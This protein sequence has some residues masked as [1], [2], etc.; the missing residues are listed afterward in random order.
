MS[1]SV[2]LPW[3]A[4]EERMHQLMHVPDRYDN[5]TSS[6]LTPQASWM[7]QR[8]PLLAIGT[9][10]DSGRPWTTIWGGKPGFS[11]P[12]GSSIVGSRTFV[13]RKYDPVVQALVGGRSDGEV[14]KGEVGRMVSGLAIDLMSRKRVK[15]Y[16]RMMAAA[17]A[18]VEHDE[19]EAYVDDVSDLSGQGQLQLVVKIEQSLGNCPKYLNQKEIRPALVLPKLLSQSPNLPPEALA[20]VAKSDL[21]FISSSNNDFDMDTNHRGGPPG[22]VRVLSNDDDGAQLVYPEYSGNRLYQTL[23]NLQLNP[24]A[25]L[26]FPD[27]DTGD[28]LYVTGTVEILI[29]SAAAD[30]LPRSNLALKIKLTEARYVKSGLPFR[31]AAKEYSPYNPN[32]RL[33]AKEDHLY[34]TI[35]SQVS[36]SSN[37]ARLLKRTQITPNIHRLRFSMT[38]PTFYRPGQWV[39][40]DFSEE[41]DIGYSHMRDDDPRS[42]ND[43]FIRTFTIS[44]SPPGHPTTATG[45]PPSE[46][47]ITIRAVGPVTSFL[48]HQ[49]SRSGLSVPL[50]GIGGNFTINAPTSS[51]KELV[52]FIAGGVGITPLL[53]HLP[54]LPLDHLRLLWTIRA[55]DLPL[56]LDTIE[57]Y[58]A[59][60]PSTTIFITSPEAGTVTDRVLVD[61][62]QRG[63][64]Y[65]ARRMTRGDL[66]EVGAEVSGEWYVCAGKTLRTQLLEW[67]SG[68]KVVY[69]DFNF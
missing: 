15:L 8:A 9:L 39:A 59:L 68:R 53:G 38:N 3:S 37:T 18:P 27:F 46:F 56:V 69:E 4:G 23:G 62:A 51:S 12:L 2:A 16:G 63:V 52:P 42:L 26:V 67:L 54:H 30:V 28:V 10:D 25:G 11:Q 61:L 33:L 45:P 66:D 20:L 64:R 57:T 48:S 29:G 44:S 40:L 58:P 1:F 19:D 35:S 41:L 24:L 50:R 60:G 31:G 6:M 36:S 47:E 34:S 14:V 17:L 5:P 49:N 43:D 7:L 65:A 32:V 13:D 21:F 55:D 22:F